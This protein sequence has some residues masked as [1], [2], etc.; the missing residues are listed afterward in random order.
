MLAHVLAT[1]AL[2]TKLLHGKTRWSVLLSLQVF[3]FTLL[4]GLEGV[5]SNVD[6]WVLGP[7][8]AMEKDMYRKCLLLKP[9]MSV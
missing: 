8:V 9:M 6:L 5:A 7:H 4:A 2:K 3:A 1:P